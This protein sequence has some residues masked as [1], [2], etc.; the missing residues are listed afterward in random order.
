MDKTTGR[1]QFIKLAGTGTALSVAGCNAL[2]SDDST[3]NETEITDSGSTPETEETDDGGSTPDATDRTVTL[4]VQPDQ[5]ELRERQIQLQQQ[6]QN[7]EI[8]REEA[9]Q[10]SQELQ[11]ELLGDAIENFESRASEESGLTIDDSLDQFGILLVSG[12]AGRLIDTLES[13]DVGGMFAADTFEQAQVQA[14]QQQSGGGGATVETE[15]PSE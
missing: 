5:Q 13:E 14:E 12:N 4:Q 1:R 9:Q 3:A 10:Q 2:Q 11:Q 6:I 8:S 7:E 15:T